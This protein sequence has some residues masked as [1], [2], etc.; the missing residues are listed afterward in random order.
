EGAKNVTRA[1]DEQQMHINTDSESGPVLTLREAGRG[2]KGGGGFTR[3]AK[4]DGTH[5][6]RVSFSGNGGKCG[7]APCSVLFGE[8]HVRSIIHH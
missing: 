2:S 1:V 8:R 3:F 6:H 7:A 4:R 5:W